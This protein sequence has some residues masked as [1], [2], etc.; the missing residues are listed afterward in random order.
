MRAILQRVSQASVTSEGVELAKQGPGLLILLGITQDDHGED[1]AWLIRK[2]THM[3]IFED[4]EGKMNRSVLDIAGEVT[5]VSQF[6][7]FA[8]TKKGN[9]PSFLAAAKPEH[10]K[11]LY[12]KFCQALSE[13]MGK[14]VG[15]GRFGA[16]MEL[17]L[18][19][20][21]PVTITLD[22]KQPE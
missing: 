2:I 13:T 1:S 11:P 4:E 8:A 21:G 6:T 17:T 7:L 16:H 20:D 15:Q 9:R 19:N 3:R 14:P 10:S 22:S 18:V 5:V 12:E